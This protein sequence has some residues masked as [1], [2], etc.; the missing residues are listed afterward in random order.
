MIINQIYVIHATIINSL[1][2]LQTGERR[3]VQALFVMLFLRSTLVRFPVDTL[4]GLL[5]GKLNFN[6]PKGCLIPACDKMAVKYLIHHPRP[7]WR[8]SEVTTP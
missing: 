6:P 2:S 1:S 3:I 4:N 8:L 5:K 7:E